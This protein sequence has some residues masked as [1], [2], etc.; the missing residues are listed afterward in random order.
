MTV[1]RKTKLF[2]AAILLA[3]V[4]AMG[5]SS[6]PAS[7]CYNCGP[8]TGTPG[9]WKNHP[10]AWPVET[11]T[12]GG[13]DYTKDQAIA[14]M[15]SPVKGNKCVTMFKALAAAMLNVHPEVDN[16]DECITDTI[17]AADAWMAAECGDVVKANSGAWQC[18]GEDLYE[19]LDDYNNGL[20]CA[21]PRD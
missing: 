8:G 14:M 4:L 9:Y 10:E 2:S 5:V 1:K 3:L 18:E 6:A 19:E 17:A 15:D 21:A 7:A 12:V 16:C 13:V 20:L 11:I